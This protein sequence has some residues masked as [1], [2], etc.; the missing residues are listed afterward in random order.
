MDVLI[1]N[2]PYSITP[3]TLITYDTVFIRT[4]AETHVLISLAGLEDLAS[5]LLYDIAVYHIT[6]K[7]YYL[8]QEITAS[9]LVGFAIL[10]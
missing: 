10:I 4:M 6:Y 3:K 8:E 2:P 9:G 7:T 1:L 5:Y